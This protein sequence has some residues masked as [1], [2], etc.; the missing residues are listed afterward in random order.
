MIKLLI[1]PFENYSEKQLLAVGFLGNILLVF[2]SFQF[3]TNF[4]GNLRITDEKVDDLKNVI[5]THSITLLFLVFFLFALGKY[6]NSKTRFVD[7]LAT[8]LISRLVLCFMTL[9]NI[10][11]KNSEI[12]VAV[13]KAMMQ[14]NLEKAMANYIPILMLFGLIAV[15]VTIWFFALLFNGFKTAT[16]AKDTKSTVL[17]VITFIIAESLTRL[18]IYN[19]F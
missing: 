7:V 8:C 16:N 6:L 11:G 18:L 3:N 1:N 15:V 19:Y 17:F 2:L 4:V 10:N 9:L 5:F 14:V 13:R 12:A